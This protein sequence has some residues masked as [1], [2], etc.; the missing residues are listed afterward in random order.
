[1]TPETGPQD[2]LTRTR[3]QAEM[4]ETPAPQCRGHSWLRSF[5]LIEL[6]CVMALVLILLVIALPST[7][8]WGRGAGMRTS[9]ANLR[10]SLAVARRW[11]VSHGTTTSLHCGND[12]SVNRGFCVVRNA[13]GTRIGHTNYLAKGIGFGTNVTNGVLFD[14]DGI[15]TV[16][17]KSDGSCAAN[18]ATNWQTLDIVLVEPTRA[19]GG[20]RSTIVVYRTTG[21][22]KAKE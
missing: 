17:F 19:S 12:R 11:A 18:A 10:S 7:T 3:P 13:D 15:G 22:A 1:M 14:L 2:E 4:P 16:S 6:L 8:D 9:V 20:L 21:Y 5:S